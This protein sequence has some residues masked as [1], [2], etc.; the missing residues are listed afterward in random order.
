[1]KCSISKAFL[2]SLKAFYEEVNLESKKLEIIYVGFDK[3]KKDFENWTK[4]MPWVGLGFGDDRVA[5]LK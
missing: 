3:A 2:P 4:H 5:G 1:M